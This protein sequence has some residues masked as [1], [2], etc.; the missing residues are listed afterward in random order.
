MFTGIVQAV[1]RIVVAQRVKD[2]VRLEL[3]AGALDTD[4]VAV[5]DSIAVGGCCLT[6]VAVD[7]TKLAFDV[8]SE[9]LR[10]TAR[11]DR[12]GA[13]NLEKS[14]RLS[15]RLGGH[16]VL[17]H[18]DG[19]GVVTRFD[20]KGGG[21]DA[22]SVALEIEAPAELARFVASKGSIAID[23]VSLTVNEVDGRRFAVNLIPH[24]LAVTTLG[25]LAAGA[26]VNLEV[27]MVARYVA[28]LV[29]NEEKP[30]T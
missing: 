25:D 7:G 8:S 22:A 28:R 30:W 11:L 9:T 18:V 26:R 3:D 13:V 12:P 23:G 24:T 20:R 21:A 2:G 14:L 4:D 5:G 6:V 15:D 19:V 27:D 17:G 1:G 29:T 10:C 16:L